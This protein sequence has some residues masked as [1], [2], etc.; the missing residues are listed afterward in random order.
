MDQIE[1][2]GDNRKCSD[3][4]LLQC[5]KK[6]GGVQ[7]FEVH[8][9]R[10]LHQ[11]KQKIRHLRQHME[12]GEHTEQ[13]VRRADVDPMEYRFHFALKIGVSQHYPFRIRSGARGV[14]QGGDVF[15]P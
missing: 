4:A 8:H 9:S 14:E 5:A 6:F 7:R 12:H 2:L 13:R 1:K 10:A 11:G 15:G 3:V